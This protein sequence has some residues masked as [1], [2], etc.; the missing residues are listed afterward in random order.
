MHRGTLALAV[1]LGMFAGFGLTARPA[2]AQ[3]TCVADTDCSAGQ[4]CAIIG[5]TGCSDAC[6]NG[7]C[8]P[9]ANNVIKGCVAAPCSQD[10][11]CS[12]GTYCQRSQ[13]DSGCV[14]PAPDSGAAGSAGEASVPGEPP[15]QTA[16][17]T[18]GQC[19]YHPTGV[20]PQ[21]GGVGG[22]YVIIPVETGPESG[23]DT[24]RD[25]TP[26]PAPQRSNDADQTSTAGC[27]MA[28]ANGNRGG[29]GLALFALGLFGVLRR[30]R[31]VSAAR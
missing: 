21:D 2:A 3:S 16:T 31:A 11:D 23:E 4:V 20:N 26:A 25:G 30:R 29:A 28:H 6:L 27:S 24:G 12:G 13:V 1:G 15:C 17:T 14:N 22:G 8:P 10:S 7:V 9:C 18:A 19:M 5:A